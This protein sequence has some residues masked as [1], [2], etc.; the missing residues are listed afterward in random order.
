LIKVCPAAA[1]PYTD[2][3]TARAAPSR[4]SPSPPPPALVGPRPA[5]VRSGPAR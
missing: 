5:P 3:F 4:P 2:V 1:I